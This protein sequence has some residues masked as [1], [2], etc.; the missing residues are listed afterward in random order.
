VSHSLVDV[1]GID[2][3]ST[4]ARSDNHAANRFVLMDGDQLDCRMLAD[5]LPACV[6][7]GRVRGAA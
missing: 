4:A 1:A 5:N 3:R 2:I 7:Q 6:D